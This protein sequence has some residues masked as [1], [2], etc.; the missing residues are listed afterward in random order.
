MVERLQV[1]GSMAVASDAYGEGAWAV[2]AP[3]H[4][5]RSASKRFSDIGHREAN[6]SSF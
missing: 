4:A 5:K 3:E 1:M 6:G 2:T